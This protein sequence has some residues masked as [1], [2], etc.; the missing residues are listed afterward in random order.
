MVDKSYYST[1][2]SERDAS[3]IDPKVN[4]VPNGVNKLKLKS[5]RNSKIIRIVVSGNFSY[6]PNKECF[7][8][9]IRYVENCS[10]KKQL[11]I[12]AVGKN[13]NLLKIKKYQ[14]SFI[15]LIGEVDSLSEEIAK[16]DI[17]A[18]ITNLGTGIQNKC[19]EAISVGLVV[20]ASKKVIEGLIQP[21]P[22]GIILINNQKEFDIAI[23]K[24]GDLKKREQ[25]GIKNYNYCNQYYSW[26][27]KFD[28]FL[29]RTRNL[30]KT[31]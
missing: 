18:A 20:F 11:I 16:C 25:I 27:D 26:E 10:H 21:V 12:I 19:L 30:E 14:Q 6:P 17:S 5:F 31:L 24:M 28:T 29:K 8:N 7:H 22:E 4:V 15:K 3:E 1:A 9:L 13:S 23:E 2:V